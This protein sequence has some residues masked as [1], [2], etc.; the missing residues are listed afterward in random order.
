LDFVGFLEDL[1]L[2]RYF[3]VLIGFGVFE[4]LGFDWFWGF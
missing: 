2:M 3:D 4:V 1:W